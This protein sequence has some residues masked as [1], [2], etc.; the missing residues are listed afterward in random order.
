MFRR[1]SS[2]RTRSESAAPNL[3]FLWLVALV[4]AA[5]GWLVVASQ[6]ATGAGQ[7]PGDLG[8]LPPPPAPVDNPT[9]PEKVELGSLLYFDTRMS[10]DG[11]LSCNSC[12]PADAGWAAP[13]P[14]SFAGPGTSHWRNSLSILNIAHYNTFNWD[15]GKKSIESQNAGA[16]GGAVAGNLDAALAEERLAQIPGYVERFQD[17][18][19]TDWPL[20]DD[21]LR[22]VAAFQRTIVSRNVPFDDFLSGDDSALRPEAVGG[23]ELFVGKAGCVACHS[24]PLLS[25]NSF[26]ALAVPQNPAFFSSPLLQITFRFEQLAKGAPEDVY[27]TAQDDLGLFYVTKLDSDRGKFRTPGLRDV[28]YTAPY[29][30]NGAFDTLQDVVEFYDQG[31]GDGPDK[32]PLMQPLGLTAEE[33]AQLLRFLERGLCGDPVSVDRPTLPPY[34]TFAVPGE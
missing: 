22:A 4:V 19:G 31:G 23:F 5:L 21:A 12:H 18:F 3:R 17:V 16:W 24:G 30:H 6:A 1:G 29:M 33:K 7:V 8:V 2:L 11:S 10:A 25:D 14:I 20:W 9:T 15:G 34:G 26:H 27:R 13:T 28:C 32:D